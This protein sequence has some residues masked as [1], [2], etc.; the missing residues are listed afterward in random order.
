MAKKYIIAL[1]QGTTSS[2]AII[3]DENAHPIG[4]KQRE[5]TQYYP[6]PGWVEHDAE[7]LFKCQLK[8]LEGVLID[9]EINKDEIAAIGITNQRETVVIWDKKTGKPVYNA[10]VWQ[11]R[12]TANYCDELMKKGYKDVIREKTGLLIDAYFS[13]TKIKWILDNVPGVRERA[14]KGELLAGTIDTWL[15]WKLSGGKCHVTDV[16]NACRTML[17]NIYECEWDK[18]LLSLLNIPEC[19]LPQV[20][21]SSD[22]Y[23]NTDSNICGF[24]VPIASA[25]GDQQAALFGQGCFNKGDAKNTYGT[26]CF[27]LM[28]TGDRPVYSEQL[29]TT[30][31]LGMNGKIEYALEGSVF[32]GGAVIKWLRDEVGLISS[33]PEIDRLA[34]SVPDTNGA[35]LVPAF[36]GLG[37]PYWDMYARGTLVGLTRGV[38][39]AHICRAA[40]EGI[41]YEVK[42]V[43]DTMVKDSGTKINTLN[44]DGGAC[45]SNIMMQ[46]QADILNTKVCRPKNVETTA[47][48]AAYLAGLATGFWK[49]K[50]EILE[51]RETERIFSPN[52]DEAKRDELY[53]GWKKA[54]ERAKNWVDN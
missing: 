36:V 34:E 42:D 25:I 44:V 8:V 10:I 15:I 1:D 3:Y 5:F 17:F 7:E 40:L 19:L 54:V 50:E 46:F 14:E 47:L 31:A 21:D 41:A 29:L 30:I 51:R 32:I 38:K 48:G 52:M 20:R 11:C 37:T 13:G 45:V 6:H 9:N 33:A 43:L 39:K 12:R 18:D 2:R 53:K 26:G 49:S 27:M 16:T 22:I 24:T 35:Y 28:N 23:C 4:S